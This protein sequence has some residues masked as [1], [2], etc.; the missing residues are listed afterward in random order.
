MGNKKIIQYFVKPWEEGFE[1]NQ[2]QDQIIVGKQWVSKTVL[3][4]FGYDYKEYGEG[5]YAIVGKLM[6][7][8]LPTSPLLQYDM[9][10]ASLSTMFRTY[11]KRP[12]LEQ[13]FYCGVWL[14][15]SP[16]RQLSAKGA[17]LLRFYYWLC[18]R[19]MVTRKGTYHSRKAMFWSLKN[20]SPVT[21][22]GGWHVLEEVEAWYQLVISGS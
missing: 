18:S 6:P 7:V 14:R 15:D 22:G 10:N 9:A 12:P 1:H 11:M 20:Q 3:D 5:S 16:S 19:S 17:R 4:G 8:S 13:R 21:K 2:P